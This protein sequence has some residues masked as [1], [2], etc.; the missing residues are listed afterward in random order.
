[1]FR[2]HKSAGLPEAS[3]ALVVSSILQPPSFSQSRSLF[4]AASFVSINHSL[5][6]R[7]PLPASVNIAICHSVELSN[8]NKRPHRW[9]IAAG[10]RGRDVGGEKH[11]CPRKQSLSE[12]AVIPQR[13]N[14]KSLLSGKSIAAPEIR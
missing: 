13:I 11:S 14:N 5:N 9:A 6:H 10:W 7:A 3:P 12:S 2:R 8:T 4:Q 1:M